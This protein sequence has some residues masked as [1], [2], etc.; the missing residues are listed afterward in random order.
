MHPDDNCCTWTS[1][2]GRLCGLRRI[3]PVHMRSAQYHTPECDCNYAECHPYDSQPKALPRPEVSRSWLA[4]MR[5][6]MDAGKR[7]FTRL[8]TKTLGEI[9]DLAIAF[10]D[11][12]ELERADCFRFGHSTTRLNLDADAVCSRCGIVIGRLIPE[13]KLTRKQRK[14]YQQLRAVIHARGEAPTIREMAHVMGMK[15]SRTVSQYLGYLERAGLI[16]RTSDYARNI[17][18]REQT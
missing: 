17:R 6:S 9:L 4:E 7:A 13:A 1:P 10:Y 3:D 2:R 12:S 8:P 16:E 5:S 11:K 15:S 14:F 18:L